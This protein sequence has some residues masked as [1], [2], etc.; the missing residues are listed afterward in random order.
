MNNFDLRKYLAEGKLLK[1]RKD[2]GTPE[3]LKSFLYSR[4]S[5]IVGWVKEAIENHGEENISWEED[6]KQWIADDA[7][8][9]T[10]AKFQ[11]TYNDTTYDGYDEY[12]FESVYEEFVQ[13]TY[14]KFFGKTAEYDENQLE[15]AEGKLLEGIWNIGNPD[16]IR[17]FIKKVN[18]LQKDYWEVVGSDTVMNGLD[19]AMDEAKI[20]LDVKM[21]NVQPEEFDL[22]INENLVKEND[23]NDYANSEEDY[24][25]SMVMEKIKDI[26]RYHE[27]DPSD[28]M[29]EVGQEFGVAFEFGRG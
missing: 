22:E 28:V 11:L 29:E 2:I 26:I 20:L 23:K 9:I 1:E 17:D 8:E 6:I 18:T 14:N 19:S 10:P 3:E 5:D 24:T 15:L 25:D 21:G 27:L 16:D 12:M 7:G 13:S 4:Q